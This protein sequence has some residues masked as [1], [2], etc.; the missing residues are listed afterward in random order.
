MSKTFD[1]HVVLTLQIPVKGKGE[2]RPRTS[3]ELLQG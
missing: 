2:V 3:H 1:Q